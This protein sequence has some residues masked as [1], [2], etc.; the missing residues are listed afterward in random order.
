MQ[1]SKKGFLPMTHDIN[2]SKAQCPKTQ[3]KREHMSEISYA[4]A[5]GSIIYAMLCTHPNISYAL[6]MMSRYHSNPGEHHQIVIKN[7]HKYL[8]RT[9]DAFLIYGGEEELVVKSYTNASFWLNKVDFGSQ[10][11]YAFCLKSSAVS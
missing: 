5:I 11:G 7:I 1:K 3:D 2:L 8:R 6:S 4:L 10:L 9:K